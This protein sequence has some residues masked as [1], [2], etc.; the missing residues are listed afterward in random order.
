MW[1]DVEYSGNLVGDWSKGGYTY[2]DTIVILF[3]AFFYFPFVVFP[4]GAWEGVVMK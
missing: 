2:W 3:F 1:A 4:G